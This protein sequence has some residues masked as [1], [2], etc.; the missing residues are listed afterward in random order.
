MRLA[1]QTNRYGQIGYF[2]DTNARTSVLLQALKNNKASFGNLEESE[3][4]FC[5]CLAA[6]QKIG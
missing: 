2:G 3:Q 5:M 4:Q 1:L 6:L